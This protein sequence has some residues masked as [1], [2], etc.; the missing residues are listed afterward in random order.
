MNPATE[1]RPLV[2]VIIPVKNGAATLEACLHALRR[3]YYGNFEVVVANDHSTDQSVEIARRHDCTIVEI[4]KE[5]GANSARNYGARFARGEILVFLDADII[6]TRETLLGIVETLAGD[7][8]DAVV[9]IYTAKHRHES[10]VSQYKNLWIRYSYIKSSPA[11]DWLFGSISG[12]RRDAF[13]RLGGFNADLLARDGH[14]D[15]ELGKRFARAHLSIALDMDIEVEHLKRYTFTSFLVNEFHRSSGFSELAVR[16]GEAA[17]AF[18]KGF[19][20]VYPAFVV[21][22]VVA[23]AV[24][25]AT[26]AAVVGLLP[27]WVAFAAVGVYL[28]VNIRFLNYLEQV[29]GLFAMVAMIPFLFIDHLVCLFGSV[30]GVLNSFGKHSNE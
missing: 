11:I 23:P 6:V 26:I 24:L 29:R 14:D 15:V 1:H 30:V 17:R 7:G 21:S 18:R 25:L 27:T 16:Y 8:V 12:I 3:S 5:C 9:G 19:V 2:S 13:E 4:E 20:N 22:T 28:A 10:L